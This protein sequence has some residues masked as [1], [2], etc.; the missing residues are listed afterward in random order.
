VP[1][2][3]TLQGNLPLSIVPT[4]GQAG[5][6]QR[7]CAVISGNTCKINV[8]PAVQPFLNLFQAPNVPGQLD[9]G[10]GTGL[11]IASPLQVTDEN[12]FMTRVD[13]QISEK[14]RLFVRYSFDKDSNV[15]PAFQGS[16]VANELDQARRQYSTIQVTS[17]LRP[18]LINSLRV[19][20]NRT[21]QS[22]DDVVVNPA[23]SK[24]SF[25]PGQTFGTISFGS[26]GLS[27]SGGSGPLNFLGEA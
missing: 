17:V 21:F 12:Y 9:L 3:A 5:N 13:H 19:A 11:W 1:T 22:F 20:Y 23:A 18:T 26:Q 4:S 27:G 7:F 24:L 6:E 16:S 25:I 8:N 10:D 2:A 15:L 14:H